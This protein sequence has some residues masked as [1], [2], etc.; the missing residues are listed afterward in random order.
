MENHCKRKYHQEY[1]KIGGYFCLLCG[2]A[3]SSINPFLYYFRNKEIRRGM[4]LYLNKRLS[5]YKVGPDKF[6]VESTHHETSETRS[7]LNTKVQHI[8]VSEYQAEYKLNK[9]HVLIS[10]KRY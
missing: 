8:N 10:S 9:S 7:E 3:N 1:I 4:Q 5:F 2:C 6:Q